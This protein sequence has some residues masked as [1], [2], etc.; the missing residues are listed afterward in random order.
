MILYMETL[1]LNPYLPENE[2]VPD[3]EPHIFGGRVYVY[4]SHD[5][6]NGK[7]FCLLDYV[8]YSTDIDDLS[9]WRYEG[10]IYK[11]KQDPD[12]KDGTYHAMYAPDVVQG[13]DGKY[14]LYYF[15]GH[16]GYICVA[17]C[18]TPAG[19]Y[20]YY[21]HVKYNDGVLLGEKKEPFQFDPG[22]FKDDDGTIYMYTGF[23]PKISNPIMMG[24]HKTSKKGAM[25]FILDDDM[26]TIKKGPIFIGVP[27]I[28]SSKETGFE[29]H[30]FFEASSMRKFDGKYYFI[31][32]SINGHELCYAV[33]DNPL[34]GFKYQGTL[35]SNGDIGLYAKD[36]KDGKNP[37]GNTHGSLIKI[38]D[39]YYV[40][41]HRHTNRHA[42]SRQACAETIRFE[43][44]KFYQAELTSCGLQENNVLP[45]TR[46]YP[47]RIACH[48]YSEKKR[49]YFSLMF[50]V[51]KGI[52]PYITQEN[53][54]QLIK[55]F[56]NGSIVEFKYFDLTGT[57]SI[58]VNI[59]GQVNGV[60]EVYNS[61]GLIGEIVIKNSVITPLNIE[62]PLKEKDVLRFKYK[63]KGHLD[64]LSFKLN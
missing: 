2:Y 62:K 49:S 16:K 28:H 39:K 4:G 50:K 35:V 5:Q 12:G 61:D 13:N 55:N 1:A 56:S 45:G 38:K 46:E 24:S 11:R 33:S 51:R 54:K 34:S 27:S 7:G 21:G 23:S 63:G 19:K 52:R 47:A 18:D 14:Y 57:K 44:G 58:G 40:F 41:Y 10:V 43:D 37:T 48:L 8:C 64:F 26:L 30:E 17:R 60:I 36:I 22:V 9:S 20:E 53:D 31:Y 32:S 29:G 15:L 6:F 25:G 59:K 42:F 3:G